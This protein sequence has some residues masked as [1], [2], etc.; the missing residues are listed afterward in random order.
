MKKMLIF[1]IALAG[2]SNPT[3]QQQYEMPPVPVHATAV[4]VRDVPLFFEA[5]GL[6]KPAC[7]AE[8]KPRVL[9]LIQQVHFIE[10]EK[11]EEGALLYTLEESSYAIRVQESEAQRDQTLVHLLSAKKNWNGTEAFPTRI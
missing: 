6:V 10:G 1:A 8:I 7:V 5:I 9:G 11:I 2:C 3:P 4:E